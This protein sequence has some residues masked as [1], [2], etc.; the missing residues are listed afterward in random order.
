MR[1]YQVT[2]YVPEPIYQA[3]VWFLLLYRK[4]RY[5]YPFRR[6]KLTRGLYAKV[7]PEDYPRLARYKW[8]ATSS[9]NNKIYAERTVWCRGRKKRN[10]LMHREVLFGTNP[11]SEF[12]KP[13]QTQNSN[14]KN[15]KLLVDHINGDGLDNRKANLRTATPR[16]NAWNSRA[17]GKSRYKGIWQV[18]ETGKWCARIK[19]NG[20]VRNLG[21][22]SD[23]VEAAK[24][25]D[26][27]AR[28]MCGE[29]ARFNFPK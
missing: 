2:V 19:V 28:K 18:K 29:F 9:K 8:Y 25:Y 24:A 16:Q 23:E 17:Y 15:S 5:G 11:K 26:R 20:K 21:R 27:A 10:I 12:L 13:K 4:L 1:K 6:I 7:D 3:V 14:D 22:F